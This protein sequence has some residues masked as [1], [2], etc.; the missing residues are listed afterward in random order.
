VT[1]MSAPSRSRTTRPLGGAD[2]MATEIIFGAADG[3]VRTGGV[4]APIA[5][6][7]AIWRPGRVDGR[8]N[9]GQ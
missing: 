1:P 3:P 9:L 7:T 4:A 2:V 8:L 6:E 5:V